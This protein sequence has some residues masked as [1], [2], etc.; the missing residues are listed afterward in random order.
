LPKKKNFFELWPEKL[1]EKNNKES[2]NFSPLKYL[3]INLLYEGKCNSDP[4]INVS[5]IGRC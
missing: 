3:V 2:E 5:E 4:N 1:K